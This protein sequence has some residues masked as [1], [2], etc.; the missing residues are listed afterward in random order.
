MLY[1]G[2]IG[3]TTFVS[4]LVYLPILGGVIGVLLPDVID[5]GLFILGYVP[6]SRFAAHSIFFFP[7]AGAATYIITRNKKLAFAVALGAA[8][9]LVQDMHDYLPLL[10]PLKNYAF[11]AVCG[12]IEVLFTPFVIVTEVIGGLLLISMVTFKPKFIYLRKILWNQLKILRR[13]KK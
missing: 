8:L 5:K 7:V 3:F 2:H 4:S 6:C 10:W 13:V 12:K 1:L 11:F 9:H